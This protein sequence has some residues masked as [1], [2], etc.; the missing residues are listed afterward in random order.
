MIRSVQRLSDED[1]KTIRKSMPNRTK[2]NKESRNRFILS[3]KERAM[4][5]EL[6]D[7]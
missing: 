1:F 5:E 2:K 7:A 4:L 3:S 6:A